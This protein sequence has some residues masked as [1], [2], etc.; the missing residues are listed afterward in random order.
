MWGDI[1][2][3]EKGYRAEFAYPYEITLLGGDESIASSLRE[4]Y[5]IDVRLK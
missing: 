3:H 5:Q 4:Q 1:V 2:E